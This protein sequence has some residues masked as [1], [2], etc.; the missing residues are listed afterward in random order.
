MIFVMP[1]SKNL[2]KTHDRSVRHLVELQFLF[3]RLC[4]FDNVDR[5]EVGMLAIVFFLSFFLSFF[6]FFLSFFL[7][8]TSLSFPFI[9]FFSFILILFLL[10]LI[11]TLTLTI[12]ITLSL[13]PSFP[14]DVTGKWCVDNFSL[15]TAE[16]Y[17]S[18]KIV[19]FHPS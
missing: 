4:Q 18:M 1:L 13:C 6:L 2:C 9:L 16:R 7:F 5:L 12:T 15:F 17:A 3:L 8:L 10:I 14:Y 19:V 11:L